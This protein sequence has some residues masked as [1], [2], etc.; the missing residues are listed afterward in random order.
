[1]APERVIGVLR[2]RSLPRAV[3]LRRAARTRTAQ[4]AN[5]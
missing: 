3:A 1:M 4:E 5:R 2:P